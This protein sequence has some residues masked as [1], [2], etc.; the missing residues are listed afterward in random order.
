MLW[1]IGEIYGAR[2]QTKIGIFDKYLYYP[3]NIINM[4]GI[5]KP[6]CVN[7][8]ITVLF[9]IIG[10]SARIAPAW[11]RM[12][13]GAIFFQFEDFSQ[14]LF[15]N[16][17]TSAGFFRTSVYYANWGIS[18]LFILLELIAVYLIASFAYS[19]IKPN[20]KQKKH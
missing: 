10:L 19:K 9:F 16:N 15:A 5:F 18:Y 11:M 6:N 20:L 14:L 17:F 2:I 7:S 13:S 12:R 3:S 8:I 1:Q 4:K